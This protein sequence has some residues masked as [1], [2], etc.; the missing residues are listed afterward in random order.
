[1]GY[2]GVKCFHENGN[3]VFP[4]YCQ[5]IEGEIFGDLS[6]N[7]LIYEDLKSGDR[8]YVGALAIKSLSEDST[9]AEDKILGRNHYGHMVF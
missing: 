1:M 6:R 9:V 5:K 3:F 2:S 7:D 4:N 8:Y